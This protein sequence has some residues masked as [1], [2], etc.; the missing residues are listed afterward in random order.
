MEM[1]Q[2]QYFLAVADLGSF[3]GA[4]RACHVSQP[5][6]S[7][8]VAKLEAELGGPL[9]ERG[10]QGAKLSPRGEIFRLRAAEALRQLES[11]RMELEALS[12]LESGAVTL[13]CLPTTG[14]YVL[15]P[16]SRPSQKNI[17][18]SRSSFAKRVR[19]NCPAFSK[20]GI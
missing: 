10:R 12:G 19:R 7:S 5:A 2:L 15:P 9:L 8:Q 3:T 16:F 14:A 1:Q 17:L 18:R 4:A 6:L 11:G 20:R 13:G